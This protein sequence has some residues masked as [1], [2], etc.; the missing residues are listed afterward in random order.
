MK[1]FTVLD[2]VAV[3]ELFVAKDV[4]MSVHHAFR[5]ARGA[6]GVVELRGVVSSS[7]FENGLHRRFV[8]GLGIENV[9]SVEARRVCCVGDEQLR[10]RVRK[11]MSDPVVPV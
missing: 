6:R 9:W 3:L 10:A 1:A 11:T 8:Q 2:L 4:P 7:V 5:E